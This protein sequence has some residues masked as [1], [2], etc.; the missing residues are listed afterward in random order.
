[1]VFFLFLNEKMSGDYNTLRCKY[2]FQ[3]IPP[4]PSQYKMVEKLNPD[5]G[6]GNIT[7]LPLLKWALKTPI[8][9]GLATLTFS[10]YRLAFL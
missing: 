5:F 1:M 8:L 3:I 9:S 2:H 7:I 10:T 4:S 6:I